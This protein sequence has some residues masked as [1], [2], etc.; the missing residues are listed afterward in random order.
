MSGLKGK[1]GK[2]AGGRARG[3]RVAAVFHCTGALV[4]EDSQLCRTAERENRTLG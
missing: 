1:V 3:G 2:R 4:K